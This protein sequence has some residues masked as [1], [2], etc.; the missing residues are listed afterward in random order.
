MQHITGSS[1]VKLPLT[2]IATVV[3]GMFKYTNECKRLLCEKKD[4]KT[5]EPYVEA[6][7]VLVNVP[8][9]MKFSHHAKLAVIRH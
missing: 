6:T 2:I 7:D 5:D 9:W 3:V 8:S 1:V 4:V